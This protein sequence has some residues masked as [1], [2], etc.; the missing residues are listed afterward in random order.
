MATWEYG[1]PLYFPTLADFTVSNVR[2]A[3]FLIKDSS[4]NMAGFVR[5]P[6]NDETGTEGIDWVQN[7]SAIHYRR[8]DVSP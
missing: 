7:A 1:T 3:F 4:D 2:V 8:K 5:D 6:E